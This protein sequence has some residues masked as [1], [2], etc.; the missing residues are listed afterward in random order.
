[1]TTVD[2]QALFAAHTA[3][4]EL[5]AMVSSPRQSLKKKKRHIGRK[6]Q[7]FP[8]EENLLRP[9]SNSVHKTNDKIFNI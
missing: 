4:Q 5:K 2:M 3:L 9:T 8:S 6:C 7:S 1:M